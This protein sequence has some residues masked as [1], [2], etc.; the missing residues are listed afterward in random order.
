MSRDGREEE[1]GASLSREGAMLVTPPAITPDAAPATLLELMFE[2]DRLRRDAVGCCG[3][4]E[5]LRLVDVED[6]VDAAEAVCWRRRV[7]SRVRRFT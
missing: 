1:D 5:S 7:S 6:V 3:S 4:E 2:D